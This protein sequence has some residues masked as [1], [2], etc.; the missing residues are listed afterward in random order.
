MEFGQRIRNFIV[1]PVNRT[2]SVHQPHLNSGSSLP[3]DDV[4]HRS[5]AII[6]LTSP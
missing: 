6:F 5:T 2:N 4:E 3:A 1:I